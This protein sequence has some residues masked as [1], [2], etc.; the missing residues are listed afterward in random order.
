MSDEMLIGKGRGLAR[1]PRETW[2]REIAAI[3]ARV[4]M[5]MGFMTEDHHRV[6]N[7]VVTEIPRVAAPISPGTI[8]A[9]LDLPPERVAAILDDLEKHMVFLYRSDRGEVEWAYPATAASTPHHAAFST[10]ERL[11]AA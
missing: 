8:A 4:E 6:R 9:V 3:P 5:V 11:D 7:F 2:Q 1:V 10:G